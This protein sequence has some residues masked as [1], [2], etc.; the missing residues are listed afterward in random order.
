MHLARTNPTGSRRRWKLAAAEHHRNAPS[1]CETLHVAWANP[2]TTIA[3]A[4]E[5]VMSNPDATNWIY[6]ID[7]TSLP[8]GH[9]AAAYPKV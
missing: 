2:H 8:E 4:K 6:A 5:S 3:N 9:M 1:G 7:D